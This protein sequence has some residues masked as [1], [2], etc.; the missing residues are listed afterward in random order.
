VRQVRVPVTAKEVTSPRPGVSCEFERERGSVRRVGKGVRFVQR[1]TGVLRSEVRVLPPCTIG[2]F[3]HSGE[4]ESQVELL[5]W[6]LFECRTNWPESRSGYS[7]DQR[8]ARLVSE[9]I[10]D[11]FTTSSGHG[12]RARYS[13]SEVDGK[14][15]LLVKFCEFAQCKSP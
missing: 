15:L 9:R 1:D 3:R 13:N 11:C 8:Q 5:I 7:F 14:G 10:A 4:T 6:Y 12:E 2:H